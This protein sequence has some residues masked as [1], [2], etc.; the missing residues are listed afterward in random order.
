MTFKVA[1]R[2]AV[3]Q[4]SKHSLSIAFLCRVCIQKSYQKKDLFFLTCRE[5]LAE[6]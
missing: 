6:M 3:E 1:Q 4:E 2:I 5:M